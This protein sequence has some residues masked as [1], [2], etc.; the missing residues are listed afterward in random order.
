M[1]AD[2]EQLNESVLEKDW[3][4]VGKT[5][6]RMKSAIDGMGIGALKKS[7][8]DLEANAKQENDVTSIPQQV[9]DIGNYLHKVMQQLQTDYPTN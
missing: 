8:R 1:P 9:S 6:H 3:P 5:A 2:I 7:I 4:M